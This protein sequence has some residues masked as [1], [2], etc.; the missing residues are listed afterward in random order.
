MEEPQTRRDDPNEVVVAPTTILI[1]VVLP[2]A[3]VMLAYW[4]FHVS[5]PALLFISFV[6][7]LAGTFACLPIAWRQGSSQEA[8]VIILVVAQGIAVAVLILFFIRLY[9]EGMLFRWM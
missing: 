1:R 4:V 3:S 5:L 2:I 9:N 8:G 7:L 6:I